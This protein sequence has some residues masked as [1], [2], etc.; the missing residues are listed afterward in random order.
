MTRLRGDW[1]ITA[2]GRRFY[3]LDPRPEDVDWSDVAH[4]LAR[5]CRY[6]GAVAGW[7]SVAEHCCLMTD[8]MLE[9]GDIDMARYALVHDAPEA[10]IGD[11][12]RPIK[13]DLP[14]F[15]GIEEP[16]EV[17]MLGM[18]G[19]APELPTAVKQADT[20]IIGDEQAQLFSPDVL[21]RAN[22]LPMAG[23]LGVTCLQWE[24]DQ[25]R[26]EWAARFRALF[27][28]VVTA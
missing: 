24:R 5:L 22:W 26:D 3:P 20:L 16:I 11:V 14:A 25:A 12:I 8:W 7:Y 17:M 19:L 28:E 27:P 23:M 10:Y 9:R 15:R 4:H 13:P 21:A 1:M 2:S 18:L 6:G